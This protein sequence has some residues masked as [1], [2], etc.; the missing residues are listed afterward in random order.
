LQILRYVVLESQIIGLNA[1]CFYTGIHCWVVCKSQEGVNG[2][3]ANIAEYF[4]PSFDSSINTA[5]HRQNSARSPAIPVKISL[6]MG[7]WNKY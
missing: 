7:G 4:L 3:R 2:L 6:T 1:A 5:G